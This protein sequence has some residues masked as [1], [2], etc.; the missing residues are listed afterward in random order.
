MRTIISIQCCMLH[1]WKN[2]EIIKIWNCL[3]LW[4]SKQR[5]CWRLGIWRNNSKNRNISITAEIGNMDDGFWPTPSEFLKF[6]TKLFGQLSIAHLHMLFYWF[7]FKINKPITKLF[8]YKIKVLVRYACN[9]H[10]TFTPSPIKLLL[11]SSF[12]YAGLMQVISIQFTALQTM[13]TLFNTSSL[14]IMDYL[15]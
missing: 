14:L 13:E 11:N 6:A 12:Q 3:K 9:F 2:I 8:K 15:L 1:W 4:L 5:R 10:V 7:I